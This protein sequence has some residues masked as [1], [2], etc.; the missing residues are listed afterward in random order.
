MLTPREALV[1]SI[2]F[3]FLGVSG[4]AF[5]NAAAF[6]IAVVFSALLYLY[7][8]TLKR[9]PLI[10]NFTVSL[11]TAFAFVYGGVAVG[12]VRNAVFPAI[13][14]FLMHF[15]REIIKDMEDVE[16]DRRHDAQTLPIRYGMYTA[17]IFATVM[18]G[19][20]IG[21]TQIPYF[22]AVYGKWYLLVVNLGVN[23][24]LL[25]AIVS[26][27]RRPTQSN[28]RLLSALLK[29]DMVLGLIAIYAGRWS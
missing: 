17:K 21:I 5:I 13:F 4:S 27:W 1:F 20:L 9:L 6:V 19:A 3:F 22:M 26:L 14:A 7:S 24:V 11:A 16:G 25:F 10:G 28:F 15:G 12:H 18:L 8:A 23:T 2:F 29:A